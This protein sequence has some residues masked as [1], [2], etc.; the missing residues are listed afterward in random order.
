MNSIRK[1]SLL[2]LPLI[3]TVLAIPTKS[4]AGNQTDNFTGV[5]RL[6]TWVQEQTPEWLQGYLHI[7][8][9]ARQ[10]QTEE[11]RLLVESF[12]RLNAESEKAF[13]AVGIS[14]LIQAGEGANDFV[15]ELNK[16]APEPWI[17]GALLIL[18][19]LEENRRLQAE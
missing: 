13:L 2:L 15:R 1:I 12:L 18:E 19:I 16:E 3:A 5:Y 6:N 9:T 8:Q 17:A 7:S 11:T 14:Y 10:N 4:F